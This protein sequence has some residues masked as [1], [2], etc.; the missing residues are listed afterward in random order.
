M[1]QLRKGLTNGASQAGGDQTPEK[2]GNAAGETTVNLDN[3]FQKA[4]TTH[5]RNVKKANNGIRVTILF[6]AGEVVIASL[7]VQQVYTAP[8]RPD[9][10]CRRHSSALSADGNSGKK[11]TN[12]ER[13]LLICDI[14][15]R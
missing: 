6:S 7:L 15:L 13:R 14:G 11:F 10:Y 1:P 9:A 3:Q 2:Q 4:K 5:N 8:Y 12:F